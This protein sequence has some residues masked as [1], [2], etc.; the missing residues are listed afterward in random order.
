[1]QEHFSE[2]FAAHGGTFLN[3]GVWTQAEHKFSSKKKIF[4]QIKYEKNIKKNFKKIEE[5]QRTA[6]EINSMVFSYFQCF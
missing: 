3:C 1:M 6:G 4:W 5:N 2:P